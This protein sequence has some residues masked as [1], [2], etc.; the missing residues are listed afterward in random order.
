MRTKLHAL[1]IVAGTETRFRSVAW[2]SHERRPAFPRGATKPG[3]HIL[4]EA[5]RYSASAHPR[6]KW[7]QI[8]KTLAV[9][10]PSIA[11]DDNIDWSEI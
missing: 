11:V 8:F 6:R 7:R 2:G 1:R 10:F 5:L 4:P 9:S 3:F